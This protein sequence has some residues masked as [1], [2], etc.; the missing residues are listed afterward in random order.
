MAVAHLAANLHAFSHYLAAVSQ[1]AIPLEGKS[2]YACRAR[3]EKKRSM[4][5]YHLFFDFHGR[6]NRSHFWTGTLILLGIQLAV[7][8][9]LLSLFE[10]DVTSTPPALWFR[11]L[12]LL[13]DAA[14]AWPTLAVMVKRQNDRDQS[15]HL[16]YM[17]VS[18]SV[19]Y[20]ILDAFG[21]LQTAAGFTPLGFVAGV[22]AIGLLAIVV[23]ELGTRPGTEGVNR[24]GPEPE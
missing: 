17:A 9:P 1:T 6:I 14:L 19:L 3:A 12:T 2:L 15:A 21:L 16:S 5:W 10:A 23:V 7:Y 18:A 24:Y 11:N 13:L 20:S 8:W 22:A 4:N